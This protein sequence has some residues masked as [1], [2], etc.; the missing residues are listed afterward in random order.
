MGKASLIQTSFNAG[1]LSPRLKG[2]VDLAKYKNGCET[3]ENFIP[4]VHG[5]VQK[6]PGTRFVKEV[7]D[8]TKKVRLIPFEFNTEQ[9]YILEVGDQYIRFYMDGG[10]ILHVPPTYLTNGDFT[11]DIS[12]W[13]NLSAGTGSISWDSVDLRMQITGKVGSGNYGHA[14][15]AITTVASTDYTLE[16]D[17]FGFSV[18]VLIGT[19]SGLG[20]IVSTT[21]SAATGQ[22]VSFTATGT[23][24][25]IGFKRSTAGTVDI[26]NVA[27]S[28]GT[29]VTYEI[30]T[31]YLH[32]EV[33]DLHFAQSADVMYISHP[34]HPPHKIGRTGHS[35]WTLTEV[36]FDWPP[37]SDENVD[38]TKTIT[39]TATTGTVTFTASDGI[40]EP[41]HV[42]TDFK[43]SEV[44][45]S[46][47]DEW[48]PST[49]YVAGSYAVWSGHLYYTAAGGTSGTRPPIHTEGDE[50]DGGVTWTYQHDG[51][52]YATIT[53]Y[54]DAFTVTADV[55][56]QLPDSVL[57]GTKKWSEGAWS[58]YKGWPRAVAFY[59]DRLWFAGS[60]DRP[61][62]MWASTVSDYEN[63]QTGTNDDDALNYTINSQEVNVIQWLV[64][65]K[66]LAVGTS[67]GEFV[68]SASTQNEAI[69][70]TNV[71]IV[72]QTTYGSADVQPFRIG[73]AVL[74]VQR[75]LRKVRE[76]TYKFDSDSYVAPD[77]T[78]LAEHITQQGI[79]GS[80]YQQEPGQ[81]IWFYDTAGKLLGLTYER[82]ED[83]VG[84]HKHDI[85]GV[86][87]SMATIPHWDG[88][89]DSTWIIVKRTINGSDVRYIEYLEKSL[90]TEYGLYLD[91]GL[92]YDGTATTTITGLDHLEGKTVSIVGDGALQPS[93]TVSSG[94]ITLDTAA[95]VVV[96]G[97][98]FT[99]ILK[100]MPIE[101]GAQDGV[102]QGKTARI[103]NLTIRVDNTGPGL[104][105]GPDT[106]S[107]D[108][109]TFREGGDL[110][111]SPVPLYT[112]DTTLLP[113][114][115]GYEAPTQITI[116]HNLPFPCTIVA[117]MPQV[118]VN[119]R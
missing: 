77:M 83:V 119:D 56:K 24:T 26:D 59:E 18:D 103:N 92:T 8:S 43:I 85:G 109:Y 25:Y 108:L 34:K 33:S 82:A 42:G 90:I 23:T 37:F 41:T 102:A 84:W 93:K 86:I 67:G 14:E 16:F 118:T 28:T 12:G 22:S 94:S 99:S 81:V 1:E 62:T 87:E 63:H 107:M 104:Y 115:S 50:S 36:A 66:Y 89:Q 17:S 54:T 3:L 52:G 51:A 32:T 6:R 46:K 116:Q 45:Q 39:S 95:S 44:L 61:Q 31:P 76:F 38:D 57:A 96:A 74:F 40:F 27:V 106:S 10:Q 113:F 15:Q 80:T 112:G 117:L 35:S 91:S 9:A 70:P 97:L 2:R 58:D 101:G 4:Q 78:I 105:Y 7:K 98:P 60:D 55:V 30:S 64:P 65:G 88:D 71:R 68:A 49:A 114:P 48:K 20:D 11:T 100:T 75:A 110:M 73:N 13:T 19:G 47:Y 29:L 5:P 21:L 79:V 53:S 111:D 69:T 72:R